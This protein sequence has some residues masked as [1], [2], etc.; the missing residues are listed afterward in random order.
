[1]TLGSDR[2]SVKHTGFRILAN[3]FPAGAGANC[4]HIAVRSVPAKS[5]SA[6]DDPLRVIYHDA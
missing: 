5:E 6:A 3:S 1:M 2:L 4:R